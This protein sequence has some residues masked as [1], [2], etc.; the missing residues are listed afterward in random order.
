MDGSSPIVKQQI[1]RLCWLTANQDG[2]INDHEAELLRAVAE[3]LGC[4]LP[5]TDNG[6]ADLT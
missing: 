4:A 1:L 2:Q 5:R 6:F 3:A